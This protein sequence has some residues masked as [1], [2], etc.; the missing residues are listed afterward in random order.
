MVYVPD[1]DEVNNLSKFDSLTKEQ[2]SRI[3]KMVSTTQDKLE[4]VPVNYATP[5]MKNEMGSNNKSQNTIEGT[6]IKAN[7]IKL[8]VDRLGNIKPT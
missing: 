2:T 7:C 4:C 3:Y 5:I 1:P 8:T 6:Q